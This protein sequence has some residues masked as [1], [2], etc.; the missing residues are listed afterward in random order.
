MKKLF[1]ILFVMATVAISVFTSVDEVQAQ[2]S[3]VNIYRNYSTAGTSNSQFMKNLAVTKTLYTGR[4]YT[5]SGASTQIECLDSLRCILL[6]RI[7]D[8]T[9]VDSTVAGMLFYDATDGVLR[10]HNGTY[11]KE[12]SIE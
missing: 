3:T 8:T 4:G 6:P 12:V 1:S 7:A 9:A 2:S 5:F 10:F 11:W